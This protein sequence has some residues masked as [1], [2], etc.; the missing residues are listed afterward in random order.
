MKILINITI[1]VA[2]C[3]LFTACPYESAVPISSPSEKI[4]QKMIGSWK[5]VDKGGEFY[6]LSKKD[7]FNYMIEEFD[8]SNKLTNTYVA[9]SST[10]NEKLFLNVRNEKQVD[11]KGKFMLIKIELIGDSMLKVSNTTENITEE[12]KTSE[13]LKAFIAA[14]M[15][16]SYFFDKEKLNLKKVK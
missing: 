2:L 8:G 5:S 4:N 6:R 3:I 16:N 15:K 13:E 10:V 7:D 12:F 11:A 9:F 1:L 14:N